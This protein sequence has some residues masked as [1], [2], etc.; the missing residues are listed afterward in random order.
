MT[1][2]GS[3][4]VHFRIGSAAALLFCQEQE[5]GT[6]LMFVK[7]GIVQTTSNTIKTFLDADNVN[8][9]GLNAP[10]CVYV[11]VPSDGFAE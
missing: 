7:D 3:F 11:F 1:F 10:F 4:D 8:Q 2:I 9:L 6:R 5:D